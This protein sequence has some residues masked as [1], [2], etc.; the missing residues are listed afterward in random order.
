MEP[1]NSPR[2]G[3]AWLHPKRSFWGE[4]ARMTTTVVLILIVSPLLIWVAIT[5]VRAAVRYGYQRNMTPEQREMA[6]ILS[7]RQT[8]AIER[9][10]QGLPGSGSSQEHTRSGGQ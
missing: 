5:G 4:E 8:V 3:S 10:P 2:V 9:R 1:R 6:R 7:L